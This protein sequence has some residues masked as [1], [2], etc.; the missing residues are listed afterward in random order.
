MLRALLAA[1]LA[2]TLLCLGGDGGK[3][4]IGESC[5]SDCAQGSCLQGSHNRAPAQSAFS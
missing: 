5:L 2:S 3:K 1:A 4:G